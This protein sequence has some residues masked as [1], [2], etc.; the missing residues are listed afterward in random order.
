MSKTTI[1]ASPTAF[2]FDIIETALLIVD[3]QKDSLSPGGYGEFLGNNPALLQGV[4]APISNLLKVWRQLRLPV[5]HTREGHKPDLSDCP[6][7]KL[8][9]W[10]EGL[11]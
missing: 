4:V 2:D 8:T 1:Q 6:A 10:P 5:V 9:R 3:V 11:A 7:T